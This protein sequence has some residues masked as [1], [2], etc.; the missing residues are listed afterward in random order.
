MRIM[1]YNITRYEK[2]GLMIHWDQLELP[3][4]AIPFHTEMWKHDSSGIDSMIQHIEDVFDDDRDFKYNKGTGEI[5]KIRGDGKGFDEFRIVTKIYCLTSIPDPDVCR[6]NAET[7]AKIA[8]MIEEIKKRKYANS[9][10]DVKK[11]AL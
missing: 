9:G 5:I 4:D 1:K 8:K 3:D 7:S 10:I 11:D 2:P 6:H